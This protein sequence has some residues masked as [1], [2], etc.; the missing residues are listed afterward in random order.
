MNSIAFYKNELGKIKLVDS[1]IKIYT[2]LYDYTRNGYLRPRFSN[3]TMD[4]S[5]PSKKFNICICSVCKNENLYLKE[6]AEYY[7]KLGIDKL[8]IYDNNEING[9]NIKDIL[10]EYTK[11]NLIE[12]IDARGLSSIQIPIYNYC[13]RKYNHMYDWIGFLDID[14]YLF[15]EN[16]QTI[17]NYLYNQR[18]KKCQSVFF[19]WIMY[20]D[21][22][23]IK[24]ENKPL[25]ERFKHQS[26][27]SKEG[28]SFVRGNIENLAI[29]TTHLIGINIFHFC[30]SKGELIYPKSFMSH[31]FEKNPKAYIKHYYTKTVEEFCNKL[32]K[33]N[34]HF[35][36]NHKQYQSVIKNR[37][38]YFFRLNR[39]TNEKIYILKKCLK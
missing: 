8:F 16:N 4:Y 18:F 24:Y 22:N 32:K 38:K 30:N 6:F 27:K 33:G 37:I 31:K 15:I 20:N 34:A 2:D 9:E 23:L 21:N 1:L 13:Y 10:R 12:I 19:N 29:P 28:K 36:K 14:E 26:S 39:K 5:L 35:H 7:I 25:R 17:K 11:N 3:K